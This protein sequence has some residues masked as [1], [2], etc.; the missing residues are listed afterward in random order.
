MMSIKLLYRI[1]VA[2]SRKNLFLYR[3][4]A[5]N[6]SKFGVVIVSQDRSV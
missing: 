6:I 3:Y 2:Y 4:R 5:K 1:V